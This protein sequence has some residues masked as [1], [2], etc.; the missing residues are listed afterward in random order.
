MSTWQLASAGPSG[1]NNSQTTPLTDTIRRK[2][3]RANVGAHVNP[4]ALRFHFAEFGEIENGVLG[5]DN[6]TGKQMFVYRTVERRKKALEE[7]TKVI[8]RRQ[9]QCRQAVDGQLY[10]PQLMNPAAAS[11]RIRAGQ[12][13]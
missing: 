13:P 6:A 3:F 11:A 5:I 12:H 10:T 2:I 7:P 9:L 1:I 4:I 8:D